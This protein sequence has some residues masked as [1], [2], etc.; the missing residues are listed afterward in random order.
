MY[1]N[2]KIDT[3]KEIFDTGDIIYKPGSLTVNGKAYPV[4][5]DVVILS[6]ASKQSLFVKDSL[7]AGTAA[8]AG[9][10]F[11]EDIQHTFGQ[12]WKDHD[13]ILPEHAEEFNDYFD[14]VDKSSFKVSRVC[15]L[16]CGNGRWSYFLK[17]ACSELI[18]VDFSDAIF[19]ARKNLQEARNCLF[20]MCDL[21]ELPFK[22]DF[23]DLLI[24]VGVLHHLPTPC[25]DEVRALK[26]YAPSLFIYL[27]YALDNRPAYYRLILGLVTGMRLVLS[28]IRNRPFRKIFSIAGA[29]F[30]YMPFVLLGR[31]LKPA[32]LHRYVPLYEAYNGKSVRRIQQDVYDR[33]FTR[34]EQRVTREGIA[35]LKDTFSDIAISENKPYWHFLC[36]R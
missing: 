18:L 15:D 30:L 20:F 28:R 3:F 1:Y 34:I 10:D 32:G 16:G 13:R 26:R 9:K 35:G 6:P 17:D 11:A 12:E 4:I 22:N 8:A 14:I 5:D 27:Y 2:D 31:F 24:C 29:V 23:A 19:V 36:K 33:F 7:N 21:K 25:L